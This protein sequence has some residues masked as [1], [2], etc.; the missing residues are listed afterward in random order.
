MFLSDDRL[1][2]NRLISSGS[3]LTVVFSAKT[4]TRNLLLFCCFAPVEV[5]W[6]Y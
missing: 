6:A 2:S 4:V 3:V 1:R 5:I